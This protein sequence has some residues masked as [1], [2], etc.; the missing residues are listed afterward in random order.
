MRRWITDPYHVHTQWKL[1]RLISFPEQHIYILSNEEES[2][3]LGTTTT[4]N[5]EPQVPVGI[6]PEGTILPVRPLV[7]R[8][9][10]HID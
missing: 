4:P 8:I 1:T 7:R 3:Y 10:E 9:Y 6:L 2:L 5:P